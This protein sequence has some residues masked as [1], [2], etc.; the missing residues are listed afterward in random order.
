ML[1]MKKIRLLILFVAILIGS[2]AFAQNTSYSG[3]VVDSQNEPIIGASVVQ[4]GTSRGSITDLDGR[5]TVSVEPGSTLVISYVGFKPVEV[6]ARPDLRIVM[7]ST[8]KALDEVVVVGYGVQR[9]SVVTAAI[10]KVTSDNLN[11]TEPTRIEDVMKGKVS[12]VQIT[13]SSGIPGSD[14]KVRIRGIGSINNS[15]PLF[16]VDGMAVDGG[17]SYLNPNDIESIEILKDAASGAIYGARAANGVVLVTTKM[18]K[19]GKTHLS[20]DVSYG[21]QN[22]WKHKD[23]LKA[24]DYMMLMNEMAVNDGGKATY[25]VSK[26][27]GVDTDWQEE[28]FNSNAPIQKHQVSLSGGTEKVK[29]FVSLGYFGQDGIVGGNFGKANYNRWSLRTNSTYTAYETKERNWLNKVTLG[30]NIGYSRGKTHGNMNPNSEF[31]SVLGSATTMSPLIP[32]YAN[33]PDAVLA[34]HP[35]A[36]TDAGGRVYS[37]PP[38][39]WQELGNPLAMMNFPANSTTNEDK[40]VGTFY[41]Q[42]DVLPGLTFKTSYGADLAFWGTDAYTY[43][44]YAGTMHNNPNSWASSEMHRGYRW[45]VENTLTY[46][47]TF[48]KV[49]NLNVVIGQSANRYRVRNLWGQDFDLFSTDPT[50]ANINSGTAD[51]SEERVTGGTDGTTFTSFA[52]YFG[53]IDYN[54]AERYIIQLTM[55]RDGSSRFGANHKWATFPAFS[56]GWNLTNEPYLH[57]PAWVNGLKIRGGWGKNGNEKIGDFRYT[58]LLA[59]GQN[60]YFGGH[61]D[62]STQTKGGTM[63]YGT[64]PSA[65]P[66]PDIKWEESSQ[67][68]IGFDAV[69]FEGLT[70]GMDYYKKKT[71]GMLMDQPIP[72]YV[73]LSAPMS[74]LGKMENSG[75]E[76][77]IGWQQRVGDFHY[78]I[79][80]NATYMKNKLVDLGN[81][82]GMLVYE[83]GG[84]TGLGDFIKAEN[85]EV[86]PYFYG[87]DAIGIFQNQ[88]QIDA[89]KSSE[90][91]VIQP[92][93]KPGDV[94]FADLNDDG[95]IND[96][97]KHKIGKGMPD[98]TYGLTLAADWKGFDVNAFFQ[99]TL[100]NDIYNFDQRADIPAMNRGSYILGR[101]H[102]DGTSDFYPRMT[103]SDGNGNWSSS[104]LYVKNGSYLRL[105]S[106]V[107]G[108]TLPS[109]LTRSFSCE[110][111]RFYVSFENLLTF[112]GYDGFDPEVATGEY[113]RIGVDRGC[114]PQARTFMVGANISF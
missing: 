20:Y 31:G 90:G 38:G 61:Y 36:V 34:E 106:L 107:L 3:V 60:Y 102:G 80:A 70:F 10:S 105:K 108:Y 72:G 63:Q 66:N 4:K 28:L 104:S 49:H 17:I 109:N 26:W 12:G 58:A 9:K 84:A 96:A 15:D 37:M 40:F 55:R 5:F 95:V 112:T 14:S 29:Y 81:E 91:K 94:I 86:F 65:L 24:Q 21:W 67:V 42:I 68:D 64:S 98:W 103:S 82:S 44:Y 89:Y 45:Q 19:E 41:A 30:V 43:P 79:N 85:G 113:T 100:G 13:Q 73:G 83:S 99:G 2:A 22:P 71:N 1:I 57:F 51:R 69:L 54:Y 11:L 77:E 110:K 88:Q 53:R 50:K 74:N 52:S 56:L 33:D 97:D 39:S 27:D 59:G 16:I 23:V 114:Y 7:E 46:A 47:K 75:L 8:S 76:F 78:S 6:T 18:G 87:K 25:D 32:V 93:A 35:T 92:N 48:N 62:A 111:L 101:W